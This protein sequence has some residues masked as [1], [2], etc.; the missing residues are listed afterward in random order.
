MSATQRGRLRRRPGVGLTA[1]V[2]YLLSAAAVLDD[3][4]VAGYRLGFL[5]ALGVLGM[6]APVMVM[7]G[8]TFDNRT[9]WAAVLLVF[10]LVIAAVLVDR[11]PPSTSELLRRLDGVDLPLFEVTGE[12]RFGSSTCRPRCPAVERIY[13]A[14]ATA[15]FAAV[16]RVVLGLRQAGLVGDEIFE[17]NVRETTVR[18]RTSDGLS[19]YVRARAAEPGRPVEVTIRLAVA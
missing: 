10:S 19:I 4:G 2:V 18:H 1:G 7:L 17:R 8:G 13:A 6:S 3:A 12:R 11:A 16:S 9:L 14:P 5:L 15:P